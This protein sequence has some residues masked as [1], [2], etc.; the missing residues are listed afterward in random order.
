MSNKKNSKQQQNLWTTKLYTTKNH[1]T[2]KKINHEQITKLINKQ[3]S[4]KTKKKSWITK[5]L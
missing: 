1:E 4:W 3:K 2:T 5:K